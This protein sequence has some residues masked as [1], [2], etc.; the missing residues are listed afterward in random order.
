MSKGKETQEQVQ[1]LEADMNAVQLDKLVTETSQRRYRE[2]IDGKVEGVDGEVENRSLSL[3]SRD[4]PLDAQWLKEV[5]HRLAAYRSGDL[6]A[7]D[8]KQVFDDPGKQ[9]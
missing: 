7:V 5:E 8:A 9:D 4:A 2:L 1:K 6:A 3:D